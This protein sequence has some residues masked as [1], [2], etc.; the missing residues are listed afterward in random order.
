MKI[1]TGTVVAKK[2]DKT[3]TV[4]VARVIV[5]P[6]YGKR[7]KRFKKYQV[8]DEENKAKAGQIARFVAGKP[9]SKTKKWKIIELLDSTNV[10]SAQEE[11]S[12]EKKTVKQEDVKEKTAK[13]AKGGKKK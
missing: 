10:E 12:K 2:M 6:V 13:K 9:Y 4:T 5:H 8:H 7:V 11:K 1:F 3:A